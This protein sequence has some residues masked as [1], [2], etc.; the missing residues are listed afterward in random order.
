MG[1]SEAETPSTKVEPTDHS[2]GNSM[3]C[4]PTGAFLATSFQTSISMDDARQLVKN[5]LPVKI[6]AGTPGLSPARTLTV[7]AI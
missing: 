4:H 3:C 2:G 7:Y 5:G 1:S 6:S